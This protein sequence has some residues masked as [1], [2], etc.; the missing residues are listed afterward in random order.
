[1]KRFGIRATALALA[2]LIGLS[3]AASASA[4]LGDELHSGIVELATGAGLVQQIFWSNSRSDLRRENYLVYSPADGVYPAVVYGDQILSRQDL[5]SMARSLEAR[6]LR[7]LGGINGDFFDLSTGNALGIIISDGVLRTTSGGFHAIGFLEDG[8]AFIDQPSISVTATFSGATMRVTD[9]NKTRT[10]ADGAHE[11]G[12]YLYTDEYSRVT[13]HTS[14]GYDVILTPVT[15]GLGSIVD[16]DLEVTGP[17]GDPAAGESPQDGGEEPAAGEENPEEAPDSGE[18][19][20]SDRDRPAGAE[21]APDGDQG[22]GEDEAQDGD[23]PAG[24]DE[25]PDRG[26]NA[27][28]GRDTQAASSQ[29]L[30]DLDPAAGDTQETEAVTGALTVTNQLRVGGRLVCTVDQVLASTGSIEI[31]AGKLVLTVNQNNNEWLL[32]Q[33]QSLRTG[34]QVTIDVTTSDA[35]WED[36]VTAIGGF[37]KIVTDGQPG[38][39]ADSTANPRTAIGI[40]ADGSVVFYT[41]DGRQSGYSVGASLTQVAQRLIELGCVEAI[42]LDGGGSTTI[43]ATLPGETS[44]SILNQPSDGSLRRVTNAIFLVS[45]LAPTGELDHYFITPYSSLVLSG[46]Q[47]ALTAT[48]VDTN[49]FTFSQ[50]ETILWSIQDG[51]GVVSVDGVFTAGRESGATRVTASSSGGEGSA[52][53]TVVQT[54]DAITVANQETGAPVPALALDPQDTVDLTAS[55]VWKNM[56]LT[57]QD[58]CY[59]WSADEAIGTVDANGLFT[60]SGTSGSGNLTVSAGGR[61]VTIPV[62]V[63]GHIQELE[64]FEG[65]ELTSFTGTETAVVSLETS[66]DRVRYGWQSLRLDYQAGTTGSAAVGA[67]LTFSEGDSCLALWVYGDGSGNTLTA[68]VADAAGTASEVVLGALDFTGWQRL[69]VLLP[70]NAAA[71][72]GL[73]VVYGGGEQTVGT[74]YLDQITTGTE[75][76]GDETPPTITVSVENGVLT[77]YVSDNMDTSFAQS[78]V[79]LTWDGQEVEFTW[80][81]SAGT[82]TWTLPAHG[83]KLHRAT[84][85]AVDQSGNR[86]RASVDVTPTAEGE[87][88]AQNPFLDMTGHWASAYT[89]YLYDSGVVQGVAAQGGF[90]FQPD[91]NITRGEFA[92]MVARWMGLDLSAYAGVELPFADLDTIPAWCLDAMK[93]MYAEGILQGSLDNGVLMGRATASISRAEAMT[94]LGR[95]QGQG[96]LR[97]DLSFTDA[98]QVAA[99]ALPY[100][101]SLV[102]QGIISGYDNLLRPNDSVTRG[103]VAKMLYSML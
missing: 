72:T 75:L 91:Q 27:A 3:P 31:P 68:T 56:A 97:A 17:E 30:E 80:D 76:S 65:A 38:P 50:N 24:A 43:G 67:A 60:A 4:A 20:D 53:F 22:S 66:A 85:T 13:Q 64:S 100:V 58:T 73:N 41:I 89:T 8:T 78:A 33:I 15:D 99:W 25:A 96:Y 46:A 7:V 28:G 34:D 74:I 94:I 69:A 84:V 40:R 42:G 87:A 45:S 82:L 101:E 10:A 5:S 55:A 14:P 102:G 83:G 35:R 62:T 81:E 23:Q 98:G 37:Y 21:E 57:S 86:G 19:G 54:P 1:M 26:Q 49:G 12:L 29:D 6:G 18:D 61:S 16:V 2:V 70:E 92:L 77:A 63:A 79:T 36:V 71:L 51:D 90:L 59:T 47:V 32:S 39:D 103:E 93:A 48:P 11:G 52:S 88:L 95:I 44:M 9:V